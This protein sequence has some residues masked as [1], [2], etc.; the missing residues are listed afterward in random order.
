[1]NTKEFNDK[2]I[3]AVEQ[4][5]GECQEREDI[6]TEENMKLKNTS[7]VRFYVSYRGT[8]YDKVY[9][10]SRS[11]LY[12]YAFIC[13]WNGNLFIPISWRTCHYESKSTIFSDYPL[14]HYDP[15]GMIF[16][17]LIATRGFRKSGELR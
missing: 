12:A 10:E 1:M 13:K 15:D 7:P 14:S 17:H 5:V 6:F 3:T 2:Y 16:A 8:K 9:F 4:F 11:T